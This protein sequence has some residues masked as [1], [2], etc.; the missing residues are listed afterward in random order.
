MNLVKVHITATRERR[1]D[2]LDLAFRLEGLGLRNVNKLRLERLG[3]ITGEVD[4]TLVSSL[5]EV[6]GVASVSIDGKGF[7]TKGL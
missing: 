7:P 1:S 3:I 2:L 6:D 5:K 4:G